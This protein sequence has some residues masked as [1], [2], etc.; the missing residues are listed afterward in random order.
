MP[1]KTDGNAAFQA[2]IE[3]MRELGRQA[4]Q[5]RAGQA[6][7]NTTS[8]LLTMAARGAEAEAERLRRREAGVAKRDEHN[9]RL[10]HEKAAR[11]A[12]LA[13]LKTSGRRSYDFL[14]A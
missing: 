8:H 11:D 1:E 12:R 7:Q 3:K 6:R 5:K 9:A 10:Q 4:R 13:E 14:R 2:N